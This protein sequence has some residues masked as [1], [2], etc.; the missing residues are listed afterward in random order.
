MHSILDFRS[1]RIP[2]HRRDTEF[3]EII[4]FFSL[5]PPRFRGEYFTSVN[6]GAFASCA[7]IPLSDR[8]C[9]EKPAAFSDFA[10][11]P[12]LAP[13]HLHAL[14]CQRKSQ[15]GALRFSRVTT[16]LLK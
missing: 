3:A 4:I 8:Q 16:C 15:A 13:V 14:L 1:I 9:E 11:H 6:L 10:L 12:N 7:R 2:F 5:Y